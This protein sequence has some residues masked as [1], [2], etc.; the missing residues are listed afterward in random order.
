M[1]RGTSVTAYPFRATC[2]NVGNVDKDERKRSSLNEGNNVPA[3]ENLNTGGEE[4]RD[5]TEAPS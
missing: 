3:V 1:I 2:S 5:V 4:C